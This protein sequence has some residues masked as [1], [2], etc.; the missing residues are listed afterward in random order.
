MN[1]VPRK[2]GYVPNMYTGRSMM[3]YG[4]MERK[5]AAMGMSKMDE[6][7]MGSMRQQ[8]MAG[9]SPRYSYNVGGKVSANIYEMES[10]CN[11]MAGYNRSL[12][13]NR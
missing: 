8:M 2:K 12:P 13:K 7:M 5:K 6:D 10:A 9:S 4:G 1:K 3:M 11:K